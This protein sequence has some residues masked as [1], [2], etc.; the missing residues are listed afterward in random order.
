MV[1]NDFFI[2]GSEP[3][4]KL[5]AE[6][7]EKAIANINTELDLATLF[8]IVENKAWWI[9]DEEYYY[10]EG[11]AEYKQAREKTNLW[12][13]LADK[14]RNRIF[15]ILQAEGVQIHSKGQNTVLEPFM[16]NG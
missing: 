11:T 6:M 2:M 10:D 1:D 15:A 4:P 12:F 16:K 9:E 3:L 5:I 7:V 13:L 8:T 14:L